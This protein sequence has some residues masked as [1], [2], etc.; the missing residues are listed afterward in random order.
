MTAVRAAITAIMTETSLSALL[1]RCVDFNGDV[2]PWRL[3]LW[4]PPHA[5][6]NIAQICLRR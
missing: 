3:S 5:A 2:A 1:Q 4:A 6:K